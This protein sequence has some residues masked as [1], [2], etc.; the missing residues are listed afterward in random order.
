MGLN[1]FDRGLEWYICKPSGLE[2][3]VNLTSKNLSANLVNR[4][5]STIASAF[6]SFAPAVA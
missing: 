5:K 4:V 3:L 1:G 6:V 2:T